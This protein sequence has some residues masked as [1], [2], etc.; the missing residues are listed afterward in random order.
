MENNKEKNEMDYLNNYLGDDSIKSNVNEIKQEIVNI[1]RQNDKAEL[2]Y[3][4]VDIISLPLGIFYKPGTQIKIRSATVSEVQAYSVVDD[5]NIM[6]VTEKM[7]QLLS[8]C[9]RVSFPNGSMGSYKDLKDGDRMFLIFMI[10]ELTFQQGNSI[11]KE[12]TCKYCTHDFKIPFRATSSQQIESTFEKH[13]MSDK[14]KKYYNNNLRAFEFKIE[15]AI[16]KMAPPTIGI[17][18]IFFDNIKGKIQMDQNPNVSFMKIIPYMLWDRSSITDE[19]IKQKEQEFK[20]M[21]MKTFQILN[22]LNM[23]NKI[24]HPARLSE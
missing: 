24:L 23:Q 22:H 4:N 14:I 8:G 1:N 13:E 7:N 9:V 10:R 6:D 15:D 17:Q 16:Y 3:L 18:E 2:G 11:A 5:R 19:G 21:D 12:V 20:K